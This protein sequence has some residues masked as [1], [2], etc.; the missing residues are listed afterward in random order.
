MTTVI[1]RLIFLTFILNFSTASAVTS[2]S[3]SA[4]PNADRN[5]TSAIKAKK[6]TKPTDFEK[7][8]EA[9]EKNDFATALML[10]FPLAEKGNAEAQFSVGKMYLEQK[11]QR[12]D[13]SEAAEW[14]L[15]AAKQNHTGAQTL[16]GQMHLKGVGV[17]RNFNTAANWFLKAARQKDKEAQY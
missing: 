15:K 5:A 16:I 10:W 12:K 8:N 3:F 4:T 9:Y 2:T 14:I 1:T 17:K 11:G 7:A 13:S 6:D